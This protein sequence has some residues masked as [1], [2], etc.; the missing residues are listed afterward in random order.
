M[1]GQIALLFSRVAMLQECRSGLPDA[2]VVPD[3]PSRRERKEA[4]VRARAVAKAVRSAERVVRSAARSDR[5]ARPTAPPQAASLP[6]EP[7][8]LWW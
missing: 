5:A 1:E 6:T 4:R 8:T 3:P 2:P 7:T